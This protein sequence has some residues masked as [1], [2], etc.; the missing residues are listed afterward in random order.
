MEPA[1]QENRQVTRHLPEY[2]LSIVVHGG[3]T[4]RADRAPRTRSMARNRT[5]RMVRQ[6]AR[7]TQTESPRPN[8]D[9]AQPGLEAPHSFL[10]D[11]LYFLASAPP[12]H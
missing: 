10:A 12:M 2:A 8:P 1:A 4:V 7:R 3:N 9:A 6:R 5:D 11:A